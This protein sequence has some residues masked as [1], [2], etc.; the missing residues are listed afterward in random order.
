VYGASPK[1][2]PKDASAAA[3]PGA[4]AKSSKWQPLSAVEP[5]PIAEN[6]PFS[7]GDSDDEHDVKHKTSGSREIKMEDTE[8]LRQATADAMAES[9]VEGEGKTEAASGGAGTGAK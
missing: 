8:R 9:L 7:L 4:A 1:I 5:S 2:P 3:G 6:D